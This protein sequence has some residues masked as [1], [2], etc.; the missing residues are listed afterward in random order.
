MKTLLLILFAMLPIASQAQLINF[1]W[2]ESGSTQSG[3]TPGV[4][5]HVG[6]T[7]QLKYSTNPQTNTPFDDL[8]NWVFYIY[9]PATAQWVV[10]DEPS[11]FGISEQGAIT[12]KSEGVAALKGT[13]FIQGAN[14]RFY[15][16]VVPAAEQGPEDSIE[17]VEVPDGKPHYYNL[18]GV[19]VNPNNAKGQILIQ[20]LG[21]KAKKIFNK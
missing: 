18:C 10:E 19:E 1:A 16:E 9:K 5:I 12:G 3:Y 6:E 20:V 21:G 14:D 15:I 13:G 11:L 2:D 7:Y 17:S 4:T 8:W